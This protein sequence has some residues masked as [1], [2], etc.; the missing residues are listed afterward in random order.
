MAS[1]LPIIYELA[2]IERMSFDL[3]WVL[4][5]I[6]D[7]NIV[8]TKNYAFFNVFLRVPTL[9]ALWCLLFPARCP[10]RNAGVSCDAIRLVEH[11]NLQH[12]SKFDK[13][14]QVMG[15]MTPIWGFAST[16]NSVVFSP[17]IPNARDVSRPHFREV[18]F[19][20]Y[21]RPDQVEDDDVEYRLCVS[22]TLWHC[23]LPQFVCF[24]FL[25]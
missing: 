21:F 3:V 25:P 14:K 15:Y 22:H 13:L 18:V 7:K 24:N 11:Y 5:L 20:V 19:G 12:P 2:K 6:V 23:F 9:C 10:G 17:D 8:M 16:V 1:E 4:N